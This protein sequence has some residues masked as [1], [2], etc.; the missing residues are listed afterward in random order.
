MRRAVAVVLFLAVAGGARADDGGS[1]GAA[2]LDLPVGAR[3]TALGEAYAAAG[4]DPFAMAFNPAN[5]A[6]ARRRDLAVSYD[7]LFLDLSHTYVAYV[8][9]LWDRG[10]LGLSVSYVDL[11]NIQRTTVSNPGGAGLGAFSS[12][13]LMVGLTYARHT[14]AF[15]WGVTAKWIREEIDSFSGST[16]AFDLGVRWRPSALRGLA[17]GASALH[18]GPDISLQSAG[19]PLPLTLR[20]GA[21]YRTP[22]GRL[23]LL[24]DVSWTRGRDA[25]A[26]LGAEWW[27]LEDVFALRAGWDSGNDMD[28][29]LNVGLGVAA[30]DDLRLD[31][32]YTPFGD[33]G[34]NNQVSLAYTWGPE[35]AHAAEFP[36]EAR[37]AAARD[38]S[39]GGAG[40]AGAAR[41]SAPVVYLAAIEVRSEPGTHWFGEAVRAVLADA[42]ERRGVDVRSDAAAASTAAAYVEANIHTLAGRQYLIGTVRALPSGEILG[43]LSAVGSNDAPFAAWEEAR[44]QALQALSARLDLVPPDAP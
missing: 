36:A 20:L 3:A 19:D 27:A 24:G 4:A 34:D 6:G 35:R 11:G 17:L 41:P 9:P 12:D 1:T 2:F 37:P 30:R 7:A 10:T 21:N 22:S 18:L 29:G 39:A 32:A 23:D 14:D 44:D 16:A 43:R 13:D 42:L 5:V 40:G 8:H 26:H 15:D 31:Y 25:E 33:A 38:A 28:D